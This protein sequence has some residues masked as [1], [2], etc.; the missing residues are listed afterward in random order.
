[1]SALLP[2]NGLPADEITYPDEKSDAVDNEFGPQGKRRPIALVTILIFACIITASL[3]MA[4]YGG[5]QAGQRERGIQA[6]QTTTAELD[7]QYALGIQNLNSGD[8]NMA[9]QRFAW[10]LQHDPA[11]PGAAA[12]LAQARQGAAP[13][14]FVPTAIPTSSA[15]TIDDQFAEA[16][17]YFD[18]GQWEIAIARLQGII[19]QDPAYRQAEVHD[20]LIRA[21]TTLGLTYVRGD[22]IEEGILLLEQAALIQPLDAQTEGELLMATY[23]VTGKTYWGLNWPVVI[24]NFYTI[25]RIAPDYRDVRTRLWQA[26]IIFGDEL[27][28]TGAYCDAVEYY[29]QALQIRADDEVE[30]SYSIVVEMCANPTP[31]SSDTPETEGT[32]TEEAEVVTTGTPEPTETPDI[33]TPPYTSTPTFTPTATA[34]PTP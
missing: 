12:L 16:V 9:A 26:Y 1:M 28:A 31:A 6:T 32:I 33:E 18:S 25:Y 4:G 34:S 20:M 23:Y 21:Y 15:E 22:R 8:Y 3:S 2:E 11:Y 17:G 13:T 7:I 19:V 30:G 24:E 27:A 10:I 29:E 5:M 14:Q